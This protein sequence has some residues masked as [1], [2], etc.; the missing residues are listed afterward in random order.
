MQIK[1]KTIDSSED[2]LAHRLAEKI[3][4][5]YDGQGPNWI[6]RPESGIHPLHMATK[7]GVLVL[8]EQ[9]R[10]ICAKLFYDSSFKGRL[11]NFFRCSKA[12]RAWRAGVELTDLGIGVPKMIGYAENGLG[13]GVMFTELI[14]DGLTLGEWMKSETNERNLAK[15]ARSLGRFIRKM[16]DRGVTHKDLSVRNI[17]LIPAQAKFF[18]LDYEDARFAKTTSEA[19]RLENLHH[20]NERALAL[21]SERIRRIFL[22]AYLGSR[23]ESD[24]WCDTL[25]Q[26]IKNNPSKYTAEIK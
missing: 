14:E 21:V 10:K 22:S 25:T 24:R 15:I 18:L 3:F 16:H 23:T 13:M 8:S 17:L 11:R 7:S 2:H 9:G 19:K 1:L 6:P 12:R 20:L 5:A 26:L 4:Q